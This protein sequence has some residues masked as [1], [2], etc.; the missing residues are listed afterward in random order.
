MALLRLL[1]LALL[2]VAFGGHLGSILH[3]LTVTL[4]IVEEGLDNLFTRSELC[5]D[6]HQLVRFGWGLAAQLVD[7]IPTGCTSKERSDD[8]RVGGVG[9]LGALV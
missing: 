6:V 1:L 8:V 2:R 3:P 5:C 9:E 4:I 7:Q